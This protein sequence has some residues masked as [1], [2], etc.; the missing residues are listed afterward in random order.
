MGANIGYLIKFT[1]LAKASSRIVTYDLTDRSD[2]QN[3]DIHPNT[4]LT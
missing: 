4:K 3:D 1:L 2:E